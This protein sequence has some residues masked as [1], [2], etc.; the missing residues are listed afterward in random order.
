[1][2]QTRMR[3]MTRPPGPPALASKEAAQL[4]SKLLACLRSQ[5]CQFRSLR[6]RHL[7]PATPWVPVQTCPRGAGPPA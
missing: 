3:P 4:R 6:L 5:H 2:L 1:M 7:S